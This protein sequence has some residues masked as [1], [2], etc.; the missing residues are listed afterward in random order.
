MA[1][2]MADLLIGA[3]GYPVVVVKAAAM[4]CLVVREWVVVALL[5]LSSL[6]GANG[7][8]LDGEN[9]GDYSG[10]SV[11]AAGDINGDG[12][13]DLLIGAYGYPEVMIMAEVMWYLVMSH[14]Y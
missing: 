9:N 1:M 11:S 4:W 14:R 5:A 3:Y 12:V 7:F 10:W 2:G 13:V 6:N 8:K